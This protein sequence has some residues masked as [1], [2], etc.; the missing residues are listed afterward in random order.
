MAFLQVVSDDFNRAN[1]TPIG[2]NWATGNGTNGLNLSGNIL[3]AVSP[4]AQDGTSNYTATTFSNDQYSRGELTCVGTGGGGQ[5]IGLSVRYASG[6]RTHYRFVLDHGTPG[7]NAEIRRFVAGASTSIALWD[8]GAWTDGQQWTLTAVGPQTA[9][10]VTVYKGTVSNQ[11]VTDNSTVPSGSPGCSQSSSFTSG[12]VDN[13]SAGN[14]VA[15]V[16]A[17][18]FVTIPFMRGAGAY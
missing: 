11:S 8:T 4:G 14:I 16:T 9:T 18:P 5:G 10:V 1:E 3:V 13:W 7:N 15:D 6:A 17:D 12:S 2:G